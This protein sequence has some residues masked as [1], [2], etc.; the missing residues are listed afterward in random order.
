MWRSWVRPHETIGRTCTQV[1][2]TP[3]H[4]RSGSDGDVNK[5]LVNGI[6]C[7]EVVNLSGVIKS[8]YVRVRECSAHES[9]RERRTQAF[10]IRVVLGLYT[11]LLDERPDWVL[12]PLI[13]SPTRS[14]NPVR[15]ELGDKGELTRLTRGRWDYLNSLL[16][17]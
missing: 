5:S 9:S 8:R 12:W 1:H 2:L 4:P 14:L 3:T 17:S 15:A 6:E 11:V 10:V 16:L 13:R 7:V